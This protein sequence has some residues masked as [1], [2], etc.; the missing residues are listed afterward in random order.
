M[1][2]KALPVVNIVS[3]ILILL[4]LRD[5]TITEIEAEAE[6]E[7][8]MKGIQTTEDDL[9]IGVITADGPTIGDMNQTTETIARVI[10][11]KV[12]VVAT[13]ALIATSIT[14]PIGANDL[15]A[16][17]EISIISDDAFPS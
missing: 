15:T 7:K 6:A 2:T 9:M 10:T 16:M 1:R 11:I 12:I 3:I 8:S 17:I 14:E 5:A 4:R 13:T